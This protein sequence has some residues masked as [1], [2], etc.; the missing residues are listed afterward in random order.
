MARSKT[1]T[2]DA[3]K[4]LGPERLADVLAEACRSDTALRRK[5][6]MLLAAREGGGKLEQA[7]AKRIAALARSHKFLDWREVPSLAAELAAL[8]EGLVAELGVS[9]P[10]AAMEQLWRLLGIAQVTFGRVDDSNGT[11]GDEFHAAAE[12]LGALLVKVADLDRCGFAERLHAALASDD[13]G[14]FARI[15][16]TGAAGLGEDGRARLRE[17]LKAEIAALPP[18]HEEESW[19]EYGWPRARLSHHLAALAD[20]ERDVDAY[21]EAVVLGAREHLDAA[22]VAE[23]LLAAGRPEEALAW[24]ERDGRARGPYDLTL[25]GLR[26]AALDALGRP[27]EAQALRWQAFEQT[28]SSSH[29]RDH[30]KRLPDFDDFEV[31]RQA[32]SH[33]MTFPDVLTALSFLTNWPALEAAAAL[34]HA[35]LPEL[36]GR[37]YE[38]LGRTA[39]HLAEK[40][41]AAATLLYRALVLSVLERGFSKGYKYAVRDLS[42]AA[43]AAKRLP[44]DSGIPDHAAFVASLKAAHGRKYGFWTLTTGAEGPAG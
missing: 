35:R 36:D 41:P 18:R 25:A 14:V 39:E 1:I 12:E 37:H 33:A 23:R 29:L 5:V 24:V 44:P 34:V 38:T 6:E 22:F 28:L 2:P 31:E 43:A 20:A 17:L 4:T 32:I 7:L 26:I 16:E 30:L 11:I 10:R 15:I 21:I 40:W 19:R 8:R 9:N 27:A 42:S 3:L 13:Y